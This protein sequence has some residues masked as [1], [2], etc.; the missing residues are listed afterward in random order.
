V[1]TSGAQTIRFFIGLNEAVAKVM[2]TLRDLRV[3]SM[4]SEAY[5]RG[6]DD[7]LKHER[8]Q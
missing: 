1:K 5:T 7:A 4:V 3:R 2:G 6:Y 8:E